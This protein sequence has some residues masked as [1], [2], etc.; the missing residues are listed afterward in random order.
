MTSS[1]TNDVDMLAAA[2]SAYD[3]GLC[4]VRAHADGSKRPFGDWKQYQSA[5]PPREQVEAWFAGGHPA[6]GAIC[7]A[8]SGD[9]EM[10]ELE[11]RFVERFSTKD[12]ATRCRVAGIEL[13]LRRL[14]NGMLT[15]SPS[16]GRHFVYRV[17]GAPVD[18]NTK[19]ATD[20]QSLTL[21]ETRGEG[22]FIM[23]APSHGT[24]HPSGRPWRVQHG[25]YATIPTITA[26]ERDALFAVARSYDEAPTPRPAPAVAPAQ[27]IAHRRATVAVG[28]SW[29]DA[30]VDHLADTWEMQ[31][32]L[33]QYGWMYC[34]TDRHGRHLMSRPGKDDDGVGGSINTSDRFHPFSSSTPFP[35]ASA[36]QRSPTF[37]RLDV[38]ATYEHGG[39]RQAAACAVADMT[40]IHD[41][42]RRR[43]AQAGRPPTV[44]ADGEVEA[45]SDDPIWWERPALTHI[46]TAARARMVSPWAVLGCVL[47]RVAAFTPPSTCIPPLVGGAAPLS[48]Y[49]ALH[50]RSGAGKS[51][52]GACA[53]DL[54][55]GIPVGCAGPLGLGSGEGLVE[56]YMDLVEET[57]D[58]K[59]RKVKKQVRHGVLFTLDEGQV[60]AEIGSR[61]GS[62]I[63]PVLRTAWSG[64]DP[65]QANASVET[66]R[67]L[68]PGSYAVGLISLWQDKAGAALLA[69][70]DG[71][72]PQ[73]FVWF[74]TT[75]PGASCDRPPWPGQLTWEAPDK[76][77]IG[78][79]TRPNPL[80]VAEEIEQEILEHRV[81]QLRSELEEDPLDAHRRLNKLKLSGVLAVLDG[82]DAITVD[83]W[84]VA[85]LILNRSDGIRSWVMSE[86]KRLTNNS[87]RAVADRLVTRDGL[88]ELAA[89]E[90]ALSRAARAAH[91]AVSRDVDRVGRRPIHNA[92]AA[93]DRAIVSVDDAI[94]EAVRLRWITPDTDGWKL[95][96]ARPA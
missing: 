16:D 68:R 34:Y 52:P 43:N 82:R 32:L 58:D 46:L 80:G 64:G 13:T 38:I 76:I 60:L 54:L 61:K 41:A 73:R 18:G 31:A 14:V 1:T 49:V 84:Q 7:G 3:A 69:D 26:E 50:G 86:A 10:L 79:V 29:M 2:L 25:G 9:L 23:L 77:A 51:S 87:D 37:D 70:A 5:R 47:A 56:A 11:G 88:V 30:V 78:G 21:I 24:A 74:P 20:A 33:E 27:W 22:G 65:G 55:P 28:E 48:L 17:V 63:L 36:S 12:F 39:D 75:D 81:A 6:M 45:P 93:R 85:E 94:A 90:R 62:T 72:T 59:K 15:L 71:G 4:V 42:W 40:G 8:V 92:I 35:G 57:E 89:T 19:L 67:S 53:A 95:G 83:D 66:R 44:N 91:R 96:D